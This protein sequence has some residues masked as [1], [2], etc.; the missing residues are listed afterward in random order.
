M[1]NSIVEVSKHT[2]LLR[3]RYR[4]APQHKW[5]AQ[6]VDALLAYCYLIYPPPD[7][8]HEPIPPSRIILA[9]DSSGV[10]MDTSSLTTRDAWY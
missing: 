7:A 1:P 9:G 6:L 3:N 8:P 5:P 2:A 10:I 4:L